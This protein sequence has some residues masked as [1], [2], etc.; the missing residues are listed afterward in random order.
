MRADLVVMTGNVAQVFVTDDSWNATLAAVHASLV[1]GGHFVYETRQLGDRAWERWA[2][3]S[4][5]AVRYVD[6]VGDVVRSTVVDHVDLP[7][8]TFRHVYDFPIGERV[9]STSTLRFRND[10]EYRAALQRAG[11]SIDDVRE[12]PDRPGRENVYVTSTP[13]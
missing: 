1:P 5:P 6:G 4:A 3:S 2:N 9:V 7:F 13:G 8:V 12:A 10:Q 11:F